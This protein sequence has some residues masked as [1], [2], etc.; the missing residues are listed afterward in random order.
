MGPANWGTFT[1][2]S[3]REEITRRLD[4]LAK[5]GVTLI[6]T[7]GFL[8]RH[9]WLDQKDRVWEQIKMITEEAHKRG[10]KVVDHQD[11]T[12]LWNRGQGFRYLIENVDELQRNYKGDVPNWGLSILNPRFKKEFFKEMT[13]LVKETDI[14]GLM[15]DEVNLHG[16]EFDFSKAAREQFTK[17]TGLVM[18]F[19]ETSRVLENREAPLWKAWLN[20]RSKVVA[21]W[22]GELRESI[23]TV[24]P[25]FVLMR[26]TTESGISTPSVFARQG[27]SL[28][29]AAMSVDMIGTEI[30]SRNILETH[31]PGYFYRK[32]K[33]AF[34][35][36]ADFPIFGL[37][38]TSNPEVLEFG[39]SV[40]NMNRQTS[41]IF[42]GSVFN[43]EQTPYIGWEGNMDLVNARP[44]ADIGIVYSLATRNWTPGKKHH[45]ELGGISQT[46]T[47]HHIAHELLFDEAL[48]NGVPEQYKLLILAKNAAMSDAEIKNLIDYITQGGRILIVGES[49]TQNEWGEARNETL[50]QTLRKK[51]DQPKDANTFA[52][53]K[54][55]VTYSAE[56]LGANNFEESKKLNSPRE[57]QKDTA[58]EA[59]CLELVAAAYGSTPLPYE[60][61]SA[62]DALYV[63]AFTQPTGDKESHVFHFLNASGA[64]RKDGEPITADPVGEAFPK[65]TEDVIV[66]ADWQGSAQ[67]YLTNPRSEEKQPIEIER[68]SDTRIRFTVPAKFLTRYSLV[69]LEP[70]ESK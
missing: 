8:A 43:K 60:V 5:Q 54:G 44:I 6:Q 45:Y 42:G 20:W 53:G 2:F 25:N 62:P 52:L 46:L 34:R 22:F 56:A 55:E 32:L 39:W 35:S 36:L 50:I 48:K 67:A 59:K 37:I 64:K 47:E 31:R 28:D 17:D 9:L 10:I 21:R 27:G 61:V 24:K 57:F 13:D 70:E 58:Q 69:F 65:V 1:E 4:E 26:Y 41:W 11:V 68:I 30:M 63:A 7:N 19:D 14:D 23:E 16:S 12:L 18:P 38:Y 51:A 40:M 15:L 29:D 3:T 33:N 49:G 66:E